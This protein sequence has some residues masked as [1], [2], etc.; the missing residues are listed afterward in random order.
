VLEVKVNA[1]SRYMSDTLML[2]FIFA[3]FPLRSVDLYVAH[4]VVEDQ[5]IG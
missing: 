3:N 5:P 2:A 1:V 4:K